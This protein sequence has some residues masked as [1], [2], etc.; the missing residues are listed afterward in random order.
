MKGAGHGSVALA[1]LALFCLSA[2]SSGC[3][4][5]TVKQGDSRS[6]RE[7]AP[8]TNSNWAAG[9]D[10]VLTGAMVAT[11]IG[12]ASRMERVGAEVVGLNAAGLATVFGSMLYGFVETEECRRE[13]RN[14]GH[15]PDGGADWIIA[16]LVALDVLGA[17]SG[18]HHSRGYR[19]HHRR[20][21]DW[22]CRATVPRP[23]TEPEP[24]EEERPPTEAIPSDG[25]R[26]PTEAIPSDEERP[27][28]EPSPVQQ[29]VEP[30][31]ESS[32]PANKLPAS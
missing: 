18:G 26:P 17:V 27:P 10:M 2:S 30:A 5:A 29:P 24:A 15:C 9:V 25:E 14:I 28:T 13:L 16:P 3:S 12:A 6:V 22:R 21:E 32:V 1:W 20:H 8:C 19:A 7:G 4:L 11:T 23:P 31:P